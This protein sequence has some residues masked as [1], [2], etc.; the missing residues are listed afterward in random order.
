MSR[1]PQCH[2][3]LPAKA[4]FCGKCGL[5]LLD[6]VGS[7]KRSVV[8]E[9]DVAKKTVWNKVNSFWIIVS[10]ILCLIVVFGAYIASTYLA[11]PSSGT[12]RVAGSIQPTLSLRGPLSATVQQGQTLTLHGEQFRSNDPISFLLDFALP[13]K[14]KYNRKVSIR[15]SGQGSFDVS[16]PIQ[17]SDWSVNAHTIEGIDNRT[18]QHAY[19]TVVVSPAGSPVST[20]QN[21]AL[22]MQGQP[23]TALTFQAVAG[24]GDPDQQR[25][26]LTNTSGA[27]LSWTATA[28]ADHDLSWLV[29]DDNHL[30]GNLDIDGTDSIGISVITAALKSNPHPYTGQ[31]VFTINGQEQ[32]TLSV[33]LHVVDAPSEIIFTPN[34]A[35]ATLGPGNTCQATTFT[36]INVGSTF[37]SWTLVPFDDTKDHVQFMANGQ[38]I[39]QGVL[40]S[41]GT[42]G[43]TQI[44]TLQCSG[45]V[46]GNSYQF[47]MYT[48]DTNWLVTITIPA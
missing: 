27:P 47:T 39:T 12:T 37:V 21:L 24:Q 6:Q 46:A 2:D 31:I 38:P 41:S 34:P 26:T 32:L 29:I 42:P 44:L 22:S 1:C 35:I 40:A 18:K 14:D 16:I 8:V 17:G 4:N 33:A 20:S 15:S 30:S 45:V 25:I 28:N 5:S 48:G 9:A 10:V 11:N 19:F 13:I 23:V 3:E 36:L 43:D 7:T